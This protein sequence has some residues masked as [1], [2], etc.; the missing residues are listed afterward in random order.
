MSNLPKNTVRV[1]TI[2]GQP[3]VKY[4]ATTYDSAT[5]V[6]GTVDIYDVYKTGTN[7]TNMFYNCIN[8]EKVI[9][10]NTD[11]ITCMVGMFYDCYAMTSVCL[12][13]TSSVTDM[14]YMFMDCHSISEIPEFDTHNVTNMDSM[15]MQCDELKTLPAFDTSKVKIMDDM[16]IECTNFEKIPTFDMDNIKTVN[17]MFLSC[18][19]IET[20]II[21]FYEKIKN[22]EI[23][24]ECTFR[25]CTQNHNI[26]DKI[27][28]DWK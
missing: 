9:D 12:F 14:S 16:F 27:P 20:G 7:F 17:N 25:D 23:S 24:H 22:K 2:D 3:P 1:K 18:E 10:A 28:E 15:F 5:L 21:E 19:N 13:D 6:E 4:D 11:G 26:L 8:L